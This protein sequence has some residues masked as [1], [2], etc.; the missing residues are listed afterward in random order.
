MEFL[1]TANAGVLLKID[2][3]SILLDGVAKTFSPYLGTPDAI[4]QKLIE[5]CPD[6]VAHTHKHDDH[7]DKEYAEYYTRTAKRPVFLPEGEGIVDK[8]GVKLQRVHTRHIG[9]TDV[10]HVSYVITGS[11]IVWFMGDATP[12]SLKEMEKM[13][14]PDVL[15]V[16]FAYG[17][18]SSAWRD[19]KEIGAKNIVFLHLPDPKNDEHGIWEIV[20]SNTRDSSVIIPDIGKTIVI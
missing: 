5:Y 12:A 19:T 8:N 20:K 9:K 2:E 18:T 10:P 3:V 13:P 6:I 11:K 17:L 1:R 16:P 7:Y 15:F 14:H 4:R